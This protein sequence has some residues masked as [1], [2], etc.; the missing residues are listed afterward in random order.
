[1]L[2][3]GALDL[4]GRIEMQRGRVQRMDYQVI[5]KLCT[6]VLDSDRAGG[7]PPG[8]VH[9][10]GRRISFTGQSPG[11]KSPLHPVALSL[12][13]AEVLLPS[14]LPL[15]LPKIPRPGW[16][17]RTSIKEATPWV[18]QLYE[19]RASGRTMIL[20]REW[21]VFRPVHIIHMLSVGYF[22]GINWPKLVCKA[23]FNGTH[24][25]LLFDP[26]TGEAHLVGGR[27]EPIT[28]QRVESSLPNVL[29]MPGAR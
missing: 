28:Y 21:M 27:I 17:G 14:G 12:D 7:E 3:K 4:E 20:E 18:E 25:A 5:G 11:G 6:I 26:R 24:M 10:L 19:D 23:D 1:M 2:T 13:Q 16:E 15:S 9:H 29:A 8:E 22:K